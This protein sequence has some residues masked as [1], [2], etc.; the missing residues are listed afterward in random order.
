MHIYA[1][2]RSKFMMSQRIPRGYKEA[3]EAI[4]D[5]LKAQ[6]IVSIKP[7]FHRPSHTCIWVL[8]PGMIG[9]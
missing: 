4:E 3:I 7:F 9:F 5:A 2:N 1:D 6:P 8:E